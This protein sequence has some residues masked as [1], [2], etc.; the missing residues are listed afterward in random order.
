MAD[1]NRDARVSLQE[2]TIAAYQRFDLADLNRD[3]RL[4]RE[5]RQTGRQRM[6]A[7]RPRG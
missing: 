2:A 7:E 3:G 4:T 6:R 1:V 5:E